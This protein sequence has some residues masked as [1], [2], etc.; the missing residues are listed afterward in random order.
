METIH[1]SEAE[2]ADDFA[3]LMARVR[4]D[5]RSKELGYK[6]KMDDEFAA[7]VELIIANR[8]PRNTKV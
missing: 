6:P 8:K 4:A 1:L 7:D 3:G 2:T 5:A